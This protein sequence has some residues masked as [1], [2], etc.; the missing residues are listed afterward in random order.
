[1]KTTIT[2]YTFTAIRIERTEQP[3]RPNKHQHQK[4]LQKLWDYISPL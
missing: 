3:Q 1:M 2:I 4:S